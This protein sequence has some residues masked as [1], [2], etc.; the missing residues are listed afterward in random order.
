MCTCFIA[1]SSK[2]ILFYVIKWRSLTILKSMDEDEKNKFRKLEKQYKK[3][4]KAQLDLEY[5][6]IC[7]NNDILPKYSNVFYVENDNS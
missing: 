7:L 1:E 4:I 5:N 6:E 3:M 2:Y